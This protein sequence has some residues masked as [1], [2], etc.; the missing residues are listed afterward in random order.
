MALLGITLDDD[1]FFTLAQEGVEVEVDVKDR[2][3]ICCNKEFKFGL[4]LMEEKLIAAGGVTEMYQ[5]YGS[6]LFRA[7]VS[8]EGSS[9]GGCGSEASKEV[10]GDGC[11]TKELAW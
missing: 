7:A 10:G 11:G 2:K 4:S 9:A 5:K 3:I 8:A 6:R 1:E